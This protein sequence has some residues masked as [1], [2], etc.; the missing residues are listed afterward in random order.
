ME[1][2]KIKLQ[3]RSVYGKIRHFP[4]DNTGILLAK[5]AGKKC[6]NKE[7]I[8]ILKSLGYEIEFV[9]WDGER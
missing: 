5:L 9:P 8:N 2:M 1:D 3:T 7:R 6:L 4:V